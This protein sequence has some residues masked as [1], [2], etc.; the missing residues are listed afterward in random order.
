MGAIGMYIFLIR[1]KIT[2]LIA[3]FS[4]L[5]FGLSCHFIGLIEIGHNTKFRAIMYIPWI[6]MFFDD[7]RKS[8][9]L[10][11][12]GFLSIFMIHQLRQGHFQISY[13]TYLM[14]FI[15]WIVYLIDSIKN[16]NQREY[17]HFTVLFASALVITILAVANPY[18]SIYEY[19]KETMRGGAAGL[20]YNYATDWSFGIEELLT[21]LIPGFF[22]GIG[23]TYWGTMPFTQTFMYMGIIVFFLGIFSCIYQFKDIRV[24]T[25]TIICSIF[26]L[27]SFGKHFP[28]LSKL[29]INYLPLFN[30]FRVPAMILAIV[31]FAFPVL[32]AFGISLCIK[33][34]K[35][36][37]VVFNQTI[38]ISLYVAIGLFIIFS[39]NAISSNYSFEKNGQNLQPNVLTNLT[40]QRSTILQ[41]SAQQSLGLLICALAVLW[42]MIKGFLKKNVAIIILIALT[43]I[44]LS[45]VNKH[46]LKPENL[47]KFTDLY[48]NFEPLK[49]DILLQEDESIYRILPFDE[50]QDNRW[51]YY[52]QSIGGYHGAKLK[53]YND[54]IMRCLHSEITAGIPINWNII[55]MLNVKYVIFNQRHDLTKTPLQLVEPLE[56]I[57]RSKTYATYENIDCLPRAWFV[58]NS[59][60]IKERERIFLKLNDPIFNPKNTAILENEIETFG[61]DE[62]GVI[63]IEEKDF[64][65]AS[66]ITQNNTD[67]LMVVS[68]IYYPAGWNF[69]IDNKKV[70]HFPV[71]YVLRGLIVPSGNHKIEMK[72]EPKTYSISIKLSILGIILAF[73]TT[74]YGIYLFYKENYGKGIVY[75]IK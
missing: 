57:D 29:L 24:K 11:S 66:W 5:S 4:A 50:F 64:H 37:D 20:D 22:G 35:A 38:L 69:Y 31:Q 7:L 39:T 13:Y 30:K 49:T 28:W 34:I 59:E 9:R 3:L 63:M 23:L 45:L 51:T 71:N 42:V 70:E 18:L 21:F 43:V 75:K 53:R 1:Q 40:K 52:H 19:Q 55:N 44:D 2:P 16:K 27:M 73:A 41:H 10:M 72:F 68:E 74:I 65:Y 67:A 8:R 6:F 15:Y 36:N 48:E 25:L 60:V 62:N 33:K 17:L 56:R 14:M 54:I 46:H 47:K 12:L 32:A 26:I 58:K 61:Y